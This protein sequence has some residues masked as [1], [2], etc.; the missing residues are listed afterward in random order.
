MAGSVEALLCF[1]LGLTGAELYRAVSYVLDQVVRPEF[2]RAVGVSTPDKWC[3]M[4]MVL[5]GQNV[6]VATDL[7]QLGAAQ[8]AA[9]L[10]QQ[11]GR[12]HWVQR[13]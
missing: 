13:A 6:V 10:D 2:D 8:L 3:V 7:S 5:G 11:H 1:D 4:R 9:E 12:R